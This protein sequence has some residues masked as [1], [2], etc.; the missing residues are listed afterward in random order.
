L[1]NQGIHW[2]DLLRW[3]LGPVERVVARC[4]TAGHAIAVEDVALGL[5]TFASG[6]LGVLEVSTAVYPG[7]AERLEISGS[8][9]TAI[10]EAGGLTAWEL[11]AEQGETGP[12]GKALRSHERRAGLEEGEAGRPH[13]AGHRAQL[14]DLLAAI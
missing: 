12:Y 13:Y 1:M 4:A 9:G 11:K 5:V 2:A 3:M 14:V 8:G 10:L 6:A 7:F